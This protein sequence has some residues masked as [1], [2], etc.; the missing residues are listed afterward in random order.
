MHRSSPTAFIALYL[1]SFC[2]DELDGR[3]ARLFHQTTVFGA[4]LDMVTDRCATT[5]L[6]A[7]LGALYQAYLPLTLSLI[8]LDVF[9][10]WFQ[11]Y[12]STKEGQSSHKTSRNP[13]VRM[14]Y[15][16][17]LFMGFCC[18]SCEALYLAVFMLHPQVS[19]RLGFL[20]H[21]NISLPKPTLPFLRTLLHVA[22]D[23]G[24][25]WPAVMRELSA[26]RPV[27]VAYATLL[28]LVSWP[29]FVVKQITNVL[30]LRS[31]ST[32]LLAL[33]TPAKTTRR[34]VGVEPK[35][36]NTRTTTTTTTT[37]AST[38]R[39]TTTTTTTTTAT[40]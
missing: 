23:V 15:A 40:V 7:L 21:I 39:T 25:P 37:T 10:H 2:C 13:L 33:D 4:V 24:V 19:H 29:G 18:C 22:R 8:M 36:R 1:F 12:T 6:L 35:G 27:P 11:M 16:S 28:L 17:R 34:P 14:Y 20:G 31:S 9:S 38:R 5:A 30:Q 3:L 26:G 32:V